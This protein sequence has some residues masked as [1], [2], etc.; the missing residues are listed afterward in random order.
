MLPP[1]RIGSGHDVHRLVEGHPLV[2][3]GV[4]IASPVGFDTHSDGDV[5]SHALVDALAGA[6]A[7]GDLGT[8]FPEDDPQAEDA[9]S[10][11]FVV[12]LAG[13]VRAAGYEIANVDS[14]VVLGTT[15]LRPHLEPMRDNLAAALGIDA[16]QVSVKARSNDGLGDSGTGRAC[17]AWATVLIYPA[18]ADD[19]ASLSSL[20]ITADAGG[21]RPSGRDSGPLGRIV[22][23]HAGAGFSMIEVAADEDAALR[24]DWGADDGRVRIQP[25]RIGLV[26]AASNHYPEVEVAAWETE[27]P[28]NPGSRKVP[29]DTLGTWSVVFPS[30]QAQVWSSDSYPGD[31]LPLDLPPSPGGR[32]R[33]RIAV[34]CKE[35]GD[36]DLDAYVDAYNEKHNEAPVGVERFVIDFWPT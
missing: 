21:R 31:E 19:T 26:S 1:F 16:M 18:A 9:R 5:L 10:L 12:H 23:R 2:L 6:I 7:D 17:E 29:L 14:F 3:G 32:Y 33:V 11:D 22:E 20:S 34:G 24:D 4:V 36:L 25:G 28:P 8:H 15:R 13:L 35:L 27:P 30:Q